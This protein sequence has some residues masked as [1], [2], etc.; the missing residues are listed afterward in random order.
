MAVSFIYLRYIQ[1]ERCVWSTSRTRT[2]M[3]HRGHA[4]KGKLSSSS[5]SGSS[6]SNN[7]PHQDQQGPLPPPPV[8]PSLHL[9]PDVAYTSSAT[10]PPLVVGVPAV[11]VLVLDDTGGLTGP[12]YSSSS[13][14]SS[15]LASG[16]K[17]L[18]P[19]MKVNRYSSCCSGRERQG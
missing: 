13:M 1:V 18:G 9:L 6:S 4:K 10:A 16:L 15:Y 2:R 19:G 11:V 17:A 5:S 7:P 8:R 12:T 3:D 14:G